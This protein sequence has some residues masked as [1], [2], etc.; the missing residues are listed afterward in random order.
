MFAGGLTFPFDRTRVR[1]LFP[2]ASDVRS[3]GDINNIVID[4]D[5]WEVACAVSRVVRAGSPCL[6]R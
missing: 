2:E 6:V 1:F 5:V 4:A 3:D